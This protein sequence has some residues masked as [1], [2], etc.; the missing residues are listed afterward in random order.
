MDLAKIS[1]ATRDFESRMQALLIPE[2]EIKPI[3]TIFEDRYYFPKVTHIV[4]YIREKYGMVLPRSKS[5]KTVALRAAQVVLQ[6][7]GLEKLQGD[8]SKIREHFSRKPEVRKVNVHMMEIEDI[9]KEFN[10][11]SKYPTVESIRAAVK[12]IVPSKKISKL[13]SR[14]NIIKVITDEVSRAR[15]IRVFSKKGD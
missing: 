4:D 12:G 14:D 15:S 5:R 7:N 6:N 9:Q 3:L 8:L 11:V 13:E 2:K 10:D 1:E